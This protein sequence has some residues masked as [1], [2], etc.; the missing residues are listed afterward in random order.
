MTDLSGEI[1]EDDLRNLRLISACTSGLWAF[2]AG[3]LIGAFVFVIE[4]LPLPPMAGK[5]QTE[6]QPDSDNEAGK[7]ELPDGNRESRLQCARP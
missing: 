2:S 4:G 1:P 6:T 7:I 5:I 3:L